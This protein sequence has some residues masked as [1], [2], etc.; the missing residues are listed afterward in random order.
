MRKFNNF[1]ENITDYSQED[2]HLV[3]VKD[4]SSVDFFCDNSGKCEEN[5]HLKPS[6]IIPDWEKIYQEFRIME[7]LSKASKRNIPGPLRGLEAENRK[8]YL[9]RNIEYLEQKRFFKKYKGVF[10]ENTQVGGPVQL[11]FLNPDA[12]ELRNA[13]FLISADC[14]PFIYPEFKRKFLEN[15]VLIL[16]CPK[17]DATTKAYIEKLAYIFETKNIKY[18]FFRETCAS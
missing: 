11:M 16:F 1:I 9:D 10:N 5:F 2:L 14:A 7:N 17:N 6:K 8:D 12:A 18:P 4:T 3:N 13:D 15:K